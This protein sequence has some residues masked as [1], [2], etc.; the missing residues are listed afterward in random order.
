MIPLPAA[1]TT[2]SQDTIIVTIKAGFNSIAFILKETG[3]ATSVFTSTGSAQPP[4]YPVGTTSGYVEDFNSGDHNY[5]ALG[6]SI[7][8]LNLKQFTANTDGNADL[9]TNGELAVTA[10]DTMELLYNGATLDSASIGFNS[11]SFHFDPSVVS[12]VTTSS[13]SASNLI[14][15]ITDPDENLNPVAKDVIGFADNSA[16]L[17]GSPGTGSSRVQIEAIDQITGSTLSMSGADI[18]ARHIM[19]VETDNNTGVFSAIGKVFGANTVT[20]SSQQGNLLVGSQTTPAYAGQDI[21]FGKP[22]NPNSVGCI[23]RI[24]EAN[25]SGRIGLYEAK[26]TTGTGAS[27]DPIVGLL[28]VLGFTTG[29]DFIN[30]GTSTFGIEGVTVGITTTRVVAISRTTSAFGSQT[31]QGGKSRD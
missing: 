24:I 7:I 10:G 28:P 26:G 2:G 31:E 29:S 12:P 20:S 17:A 21:T 30:K 6:A 5:P 22:S 16:L 15:S 19:L 11:G 1:N 4:V 9:R 14:I 8:G 25:A 3:G 23:F 18:I 27:N 13:L